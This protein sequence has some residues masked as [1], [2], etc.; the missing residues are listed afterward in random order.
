MEPLAES[1]PRRVGGYT[2]LARL[3]TG[4][5]GIV[6]AA[7]DARGSDVALKVLRPELADNES[8]RGRLRREAEILRRVSGPRTVKFLEIDAD[9]H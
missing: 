7:R 6:Y 8:V 1:D 9:F 4:A 3:G 2:I 5:S